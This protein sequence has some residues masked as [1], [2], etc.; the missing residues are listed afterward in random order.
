MRLINTNLLN[1]FY[2]NGVKPLKDAI[3][4]KLDAN[5][6]ANNLLTTV[7]GYGLDARQG[8][9]IQGEIDSINSNLSE[10]KVILDWQNA[11]DLTNTVFQTSAT[12]KYTA[13]KRGIIIGFQAP[14][15]NMSW[16]NATIANVTVMAINSMA[17]QRIPFNFPVNKNDVVSFYGDNNVSKNVYCGCWF[18]PYK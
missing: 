10:L 13:P 9:V 5:K 4:N 1:Y 18:V 16:Y 11:V 7:K 12:V 15:E 14:L 6:L 3:A 8:P 2:K 17:R